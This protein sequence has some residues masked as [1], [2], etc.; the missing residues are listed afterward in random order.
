MSIKVVLENPWV[1]V[2]IILAAL[3]LL[4]F[5]VYALSFVLVPLLMAFLVAYVLD[6][7]VDWFEAR[8][9][10]RSVAIM[11]LAMLGLGVALSVPLIAVPSLIDQAERFSARAQQVAK[12]DNQGAIASWVGIVTDKLP[13]DRIV[14]SAGWR[15]E[16]EN[17]TP[18]VPAVETEEPSPSANEEEVG[19]EEDGEAEAEIEASEPEAKATDDAPVAVSPTPA[20]AVIAW[21]IAETVRSNLLTWVRDYGG[22]AAATGKTA[23]ASLATLLS[24][25]GAG[26]AEVVVFFGNLAVLSFVGGFLLRDYDYVVAEM[27]KLVPPKWRTNVFRIMGKIDSQLRNFLM[28]QGTVC[29][30]LAIMYWI[31]LWMAGVPFAGAIALFGG[32]ATLIP[33]FGVVLT[34]VPSFAFSLMYH[35]VG[36]N[37]VWVVVVFVIVQALE[38]NVVT[39]F[40][41]GQ[42]VGLHPVWVILAVIVF[43]SLLGFTGLLIAVPLAAVLKVLVVESVDAYKASSLFAEDEV[44]PVAGSD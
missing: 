29:A 18:I 22:T 13:L 40:I 33:F 20:S 17:R 39:P 28:G 15:E 19:A 3:G 30:A 21:K 12:Q 37:L 2:G 23:G 25:V 41:M 10:S 27:G 11:A 24:S 32:F 42:R 1:R 38:G 14:E 36:M 26:L 35:G 9:V 6:P 44:K 31:G 43:G 34:F 4:C 16:Y 5:S 7:V 8:R